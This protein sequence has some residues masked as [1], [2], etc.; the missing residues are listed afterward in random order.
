[1]KQG[2]SKVKGFE[3]YTPEEIAALKKAV[4]GTKTGNL[5]RGV[6]KYLGG[7]GGA[8]NAGVGT[9][10]GGATYHETGNPYDAIAAGAAASLGARGLNRIGNRM[11]TNRAAA[12]DELLRSRSPLAAPIVARNEAAIRQAVEARLRALGITGAISAQQQQR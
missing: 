6:A 1:M 7:G 5:V 4:V 11:A 8:W 10:A 12:V 2:V 9:I 3:D